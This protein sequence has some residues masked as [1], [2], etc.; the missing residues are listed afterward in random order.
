MNVLHDIKRMLR[1]EVDQIYWGIANNI[2]AWIR[3]SKK[4]SKVN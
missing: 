2:E 4:I 1:N 3:T